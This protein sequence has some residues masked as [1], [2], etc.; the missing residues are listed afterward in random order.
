MSSSPGLSRC[1]TL[2]AGQQYLTLHPLRSMGALIL[3]PAKIRFLP[4][5][6]ISIEVFSI[7]HNGIAEKSQYRFTGSIFCF[8][9]FY[10]HTHSVCAGRNDCLWC[11]VV[12]HVIPCFFLVVPQCFSWLS[13]VRCSLLIVQLFVCI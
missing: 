7:L 2:P 3:F 6:T 12:L 11:C 5:A 10:L 8:A 9:V 4:R 13:K 1:Q